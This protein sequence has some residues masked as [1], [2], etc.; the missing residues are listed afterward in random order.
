MK[1]QKQL[2]YMLAKRKIIDQT[3]L[4]AMAKF[5]RALFVPKNFLDK[6][7]DDIA[8]PIAGGQTI[9]QPSIVG[10]MS[11]ELD[12]HPRH[13]ILEI[14]TGSAYQ[15]AVL[16]QLARRVYSI[17]RHQKLA[18]T[19][20]TLLEKLKIDNV[21]VLNRDG[22]HGLP[23]QAPFD[24]IIVTA[25]S[26]NIPPKLLQQLK[27][28][29]KI[30]I[31]IGTTDRIQRLIKATRTPEGYEYDELCDVCFVPLREGIVKSTTKAKTKEI[32]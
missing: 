1:N 21:L 2:L 8:L 15:A 13:K 4:N 7:H 10:I 18:R 25:A 30:I 5:D 27:I 28:G 17:E 6:A 32:N 20:Q 26:E 14:G 19:A 29:G 31:P 3:I 11:Q 16:S 24:R 12:V 22:I 9:S 23:E